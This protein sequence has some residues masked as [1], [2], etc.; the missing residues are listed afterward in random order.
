[1]DGIL[2]LTNWTDE[3]FVTT[4]DSQEY[5]F[6]A[7]KKTPVIVGSPLENQEVRKLFAK[8]LCEREIFAGRA[9]KAN[10]KAAHKT[11]E[12]VGGIYTDHDL[13]P[14]MAMC[15]TDMEKAE[16][17][18]TPVPKKELRGKKVMIPI[19]EVENSG[20]LAGV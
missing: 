16:P 5:L 13:E 15:L 20:A 18:V 9:W 7:G 11:G 2:Y 19:D 1:M 3:D 8:K 6:P 10:E 4:W 12:M 17:R 14:M